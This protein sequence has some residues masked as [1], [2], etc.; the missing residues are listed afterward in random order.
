VSAIGGS[1]TLTI[2]TLTAAG[3]TGTFAFTAVP[4]QAG[5]AGA[6]G[7]KVVTNGTFNVT[8]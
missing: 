6:T 4:P 8:F 5:G 3:A 7:T 1:G 2:A